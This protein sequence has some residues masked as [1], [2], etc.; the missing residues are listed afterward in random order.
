[1]GYQ[2]GFIIVKG[3]PAFAAHVQLAGR[4]SDL[5]GSKA[6]F[7]MV[8]INGKLREF[9][10]DRILLLNLW[11]GDKTFLKMLID[12][13][14][15]FSMKVSYDKDELKEITVYTPDK[16]ENVTGGQVPC[17]IIGDKK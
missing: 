2:P 11:E 12:G 16:K 5:I 8:V 15:F 13:V 17:H 1:M 4:Q 6:V 3:F 7:N 14:P 10:K 9:E